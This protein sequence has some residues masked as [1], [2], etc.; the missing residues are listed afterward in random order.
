MAARTK[1]VTEVRRCA[2]VLRDGTTCRTHAEPDGAFCR[3]HL[4]NPWPAP[5]E[6]KQEEPSDLEVLADVLPDHEA[7]ASGSRDVR[8]AFR[9]A[10]PD[11]F[12]EMKTA[13][14]GAMRERTTVYAVCK[15][16]KRK[17]AFS[18]PAPAGRAKA[19]ETF[20]KLGFGAVTPEAPTSM[21]DDGMAI[22]EAVIAEL[23]PE[24][25]D[26]VR[27]R[28]KAEHRLHLARPAT[29]GADST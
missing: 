20:V 24:E 4:E 21:S 3:Y 13:L 28:L 8:L 1:K 12:D 22:A 11:H 16:C 10:A 18:V 29:S 2:A 25:R 9:R 17:K 23:T 15:G 7:E 27:R 26:R 6:E 14:L 19:V 5:R